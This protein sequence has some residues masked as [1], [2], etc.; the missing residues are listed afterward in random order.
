MLYAIIGTDVADSAAARA[1]AR[2]RH[3][4]RVQALVQQ[5]R[6]VIAGPFPAIDAADPG[7]HGMTGSLIVAEFP[8]LSSARAWAAADPYAT[9]GVFAHIDV[10]PFKQV[11]P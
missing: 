7:P 9:D 6:L 3:L 10:K 4:E 2:P 11:L 5:G 8:D 1:A